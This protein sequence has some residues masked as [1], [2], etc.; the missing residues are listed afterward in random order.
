MSSSESALELKAKS[1]LNSCQEVH[2]VSATPESTMAV[3][4]SGWNTIAE[5]FKEKWKLGW[6]YSVTLI[7]YGLFIPFFSPL[8]FLCQE[9]LSLEGNL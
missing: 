4:T 7:I 3:I 5:V 9:V 8:K 1:P 2:P 6:E